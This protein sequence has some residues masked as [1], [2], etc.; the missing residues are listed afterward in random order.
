MEALAPLL[1]AAIALI[2]NEEP[3]DGICQPSTVEKAQR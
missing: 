3:I 1:P 2:K